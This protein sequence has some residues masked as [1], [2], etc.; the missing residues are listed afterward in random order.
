MNASQSQPPLGRL[1]WRCRRGMRELDRLL[2]AYL[3]HG[4]AQS[5]AAD[6]RLFCDLLDLQDPVLY[7]YFLGRE[8]PPEALAGMIERI[9]RFAGRA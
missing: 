6:Q 8:A 2:G 3:E 7:G 5:S 1:R 4:Y 9:A